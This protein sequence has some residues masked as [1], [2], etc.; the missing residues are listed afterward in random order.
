[1]RERVCK[2][3]GGRQYVVV[4]QNMVKCQFCGTLYVD[5]HASKEEEVLIVKAYEKLRDFKFEEAI[6]EFDKVLALYPLSFEAFYGK[7]LAKNRIIFYTERKGITKKPKFF[8]ETIPSILKDEDFSNAVENAPTETAKTYN[9]Q[10]KRIE[11]IHLAFEELSKDHV[12]DVFVSAISFDDSKDEKIANSIKE[13]ASQNIKSYFSLGQESKEKEEETFK[14]LQDC[15]VMVLFANEKKGYTNGENKNLYDRYL[16]LISQRKKAKQSFVIVID[17]SIVTLEDLPKELSGCKSI[18]DINS[19]SFLQDFMTKVKK[20]IN[21][22]VE[23]IAKIET[24]KIK[25]V[26]PKKKDYVDVESIQPND[27]GHY[28]V[29]NVELSEANKIKWIFLSLKNGD[30]VSAKDLISTEL[31]K[32]PNNAE[33]LLA[34]LLCE[35]KLKTQEEFFSSIANFRDKEKI[36][37]IL[38]LASK[39]FAESFVDRWEELVISLDSEEYYNAFLLYLAKFNTPNRE[40]FVSRAEQKAVET[41]DEE[42]IDKVLK[43]FNNNE[44]ERFI[45]FYFML[46]QKSDNQEY[47][48][49]VLDIDEGHEQSNLALLL[50]HFKTDEDKLSYRKQSEIEEVFKFLSENTRS[51]FVMAVANMVLPIAFQDLKKAEQQLDFYLAYVSDDKQLVEILKNIALKFQEM[52]YFKQAEKYVS[53]AISKDKNQAYLYWLLIQIKAH[54]F[55][56]NEL[57]KT[58]VKIS[59]MPEW[60]TLISIATEKEVEKYAEIVS[61]ANLYSGERLAFKEDFPD[62]NELMTRLNEFLLRNNKILLEC[63]KQDKNEVIRGANYFKLQLKPFENYEEKLK[64]VKTFKEFK[65]IVEKIEIRLDLLDLNLDASINVTH[66][67]DKDKTIE[68]LKVEVDKEEKNY[69]NTKKIIKKDVFLK[70]FLFLFL[71]LFPLLFTT[72]LLII[73]VVMPKEVY[74]YFSQDFMIITIVLSVAI[75]LANLVAFTSKKLLSRGWKAAT[76]SLFCIG[77]LN[78][79]LLCMGFY[80]M[81]KT[82][83]I[84]NSKEFDVL[85]HNARYASFELNSDI[86]MTN[87]SWKSGNFTGVLNGN[88]YKIENLTFA[89]AS[90]LGLFKRNS[91]EIKNLEIYLSENIYEGVTNFGVVAVRNDGKIENCS[92][93]GTLNLKT[94]SDARIG[95]LVGSLEGGSIQNN[96]SSLKLTIDSADNNLTVGGLVGQ[97]SA[98]KNKTVI[99]RNGSENVTIINSTNSQKITTGGLVGNLG[100]IESLDLSKNYSNSDITIN[101]KTNNIVAG[102]LV[103]LGYSESEN[104]YSLGKIDIAGLEGTG[105]VGGLY[106]QYINLDRN[107]VVSHSY[108]LTEFDGNSTAKLGAIIGGL[109][110]N[111]NSCFTSVDMVLYGQKESSFA[112]MVN[113]DKLLTKFYDDKFGFD[114]EVWIILPSEY[115]KLR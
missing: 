42:L 24:I 104:N 97:A 47:Y 62:K 95:G 102:G 51:Q 25:K 27:L 46:A 77:C 109:A 15:K 40:N 63:G 19:E 29:E 100:K 111:V 26:A 5:E 105:L 35:N 89:N 73:V 52:G 90:D 74:L 93:Y 94:S 114:E 2:N 9:E 53:I 10:A 72:L 54:C 96:S 103:G 7:C 70:R 108:T 75:G 87:I 37:K 110:G 98:G 8:G 86:D 14:A 18:I 48:K 45:N 6:D 31:S 85:L 115:P 76:L 1:M 106:G 28:R 83:T 66:L 32:D 92:V 33:L 36:D 112:D 21:N 38:E 43:C 88:G 84:N 80:L 56:D 4:G 60:E 23:E 99:S 69:F 50:Q 44:V 79:L 22:T 68:P 82:I 59:Q 55:V 17:N 11:K 34:E 78:L 65:E 13:L 57:I 67:I 49:K 91:G 107:K 41:L 58:N 30:F 20:E 81:P 113:C 61:R 101:G 39:D 12:T 16:Y 71:E 3:C 64:Q